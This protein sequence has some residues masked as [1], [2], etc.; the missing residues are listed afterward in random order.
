M[1]C[2][3]QMRQNIASTQERGI[4]VLSMGL[5]LMKIESRTG[6]DLGQGDRRREI[7]DQHVAITSIRSR[8]QIFQRRMAK[9]LSRGAYDR[10]HLARIV[11]LREIAVRVQGR[12]LKWDI[13][14]GTGRN[15]ECGCKGSDARPND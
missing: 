8:A 9:Q 3:S 4:E 7:S 13:A 11:D 10:I 14:L 2:V 1:L 15:R 6:L 5:Q 12:V